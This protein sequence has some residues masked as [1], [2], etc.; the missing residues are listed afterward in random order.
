MLQ[1]E[2]YSNNGDGHYSHDGSEGSD[3]ESISSSNSDD[4][5]LK[6][7]KD[8]EEKEKRKKYS[9]RQKDQLFEKKFFSPS[10]SSQSILSTSI[11]SFLNLDYS[12]NTIVNV[13]YPPS[14]P[15]SALATLQN[16]SQSYFAQIIAEF[17]SNDNNHNN[18]NHNSND[19]YDTSLYKDDDNDSFSHSSKHEN[20]LILKDTNVHGTDP[21][22]IKLNPSVFTK[23]RKNGVSLYLQSLRCV[24]LSII[25]Q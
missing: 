7:V 5:K 19:S 9:L 13:C 8:E 21:F 15:A 14:A 16:V 20:S 24:F 25:Y 4:N 18:N 1:D 22:S 23:P 2:N 3:E 6:E 17:N 12:Y 10:A 11:L